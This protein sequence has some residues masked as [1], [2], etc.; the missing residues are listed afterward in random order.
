MRKKSTVAFDFILDYLTPAS[1]VTK[2]MFGCHSVYVGEQ[3]VLIL[4][5]KIPADSDNGMWIATD[6]PHH[7]SLKKEFPAM[8]PIRIF[9]EK[10]SKWQLIPEESDDFESAA[11]RICELILK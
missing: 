3:I 11:L 7:T 9:G 10:G 6:I 8:R 2:P 5:K 4:R 1:P